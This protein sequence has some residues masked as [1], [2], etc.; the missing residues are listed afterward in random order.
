MRQRY[1]EKKLARE[2]WMAKTHFRQRKTIKEIQERNRQAKKYTLMS[3]RDKQ[4]QTF[5]GR[6]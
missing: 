4:R 1:T 5:R 6:G 2:S 3:E